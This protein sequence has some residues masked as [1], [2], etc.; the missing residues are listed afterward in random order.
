M[1]FVTTCLH[2]RFSLGE[3]GWRRPGLQKSCAGPFTMGLPPGP[4]SGRARGAAHARRDPIAGGPRPS[5]ETDLTGRRLV[6]CGG[7]IPRRTPHRRG[8]A[9]AIGR[10][11]PS[12]PKADGSISVG[13][14]GRP[15]DL[16]LRPS[17]PSRCCA[18]FWGV[19]GGPPLLAILWTFLWA[20][21]VGAAAHGAMATSAGLLGQA[22]VGRQFVARGAL[23][24]SPPL[25]FPPLLLCFLGFAAALVKAGAG[26]VSI[27]AQKRAAF[28]VGNAVRRDIAA[29]IL[30]AGRASPS[31]RQPRGP[32]RPPAGDRA[33]GRRG[34]PR[35]GSA[36]RS[37]SS[38][39]PAR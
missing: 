37:P 7:M 13:R 6:S 2:R 10:S 4:R 25:L 12:R 38:R 23:V 19:G 30:R 21:M 26:A 33:G 8:P 9:P 22:L 32:R 24:D 36:P 18:S 34:R 39:S 16:R 28:R 17:F 14:G 11:E 15:C 20:T 27:Y 35:P 1:L 31:A 3:Y 29:A 5:R